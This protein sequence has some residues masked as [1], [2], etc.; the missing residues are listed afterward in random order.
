MNNRA[1]TLVELL[2][3]IAIIALLMAI[4][5]PS[6]QA[7]RE[8][9]QMVVCQSQL[10]HWGSIFTMYT[11]DN[12]G[13][14]HPGLEEPR[15]EEHLWL[16]IYRPYYGEKDVFRTCPSATKID[17][18]YRN[19]GSKYAWGMRDDYVGELYNYGSYGLNAYVCNEQADLSY[20]SE[21]ERSCY[22]RTINVKG[23][24]NN[25]PIL[26]DASY[27]K[28]YIRH[29]HTFQNKYDWAHYLEKYANIHNYSMTSYCIDR[30]NCTINMLFFD[31]S[32]R[33]VPLRQMW[34][35]KWNRKW[36]KP[37]WVAT[38]DWPNWMKK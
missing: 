32:V 16:H 28:N 9:A 14:F 13:F 29:I 6:L 34:D 37:A 11:N 27:W 25:I 21:F 30:H 15:V 19:G 24:L 36:E 31:T 22:W 8:Q 20:N 10:K 35:L 12:N 26:G 3:V 17:G 2:V 33:R 18:D 1:F 38:Y 7:A 4:L 23:Q 5:L